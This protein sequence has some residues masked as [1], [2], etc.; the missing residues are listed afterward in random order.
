MMWSMDETHAK[1]G[2]TSYNVSMNIRNH[3]RPNIINRI[4]IDKLREEA[5]VR[6]IV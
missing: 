2:N 6:E 5:T 1:T 4:V 3:Y